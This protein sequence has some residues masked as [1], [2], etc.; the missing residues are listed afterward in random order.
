MVRLVIAAN[1]WDTHKKDHC[2]SRINRA[3]NN[4]NTLAE[5]QDFPQQHLFVEI[6][7]IN[8][9]QTFLIFTRNKK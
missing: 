9:K 2:D 1:E 7:A 5:L 4:S 8:E 3:R 6:F